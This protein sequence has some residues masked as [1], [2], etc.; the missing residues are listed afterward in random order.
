MVA[1]SGVPAEIVELT[2]EQFDALLSPPW[3]QD[4]LVPIGAAVFVLVF[5]GIVTMVVG[6][7]R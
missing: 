3:V 6:W 4:V 7:R 5:A 1:V 2:P